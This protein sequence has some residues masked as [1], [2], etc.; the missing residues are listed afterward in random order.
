MERDVEFS[1][2]KIIFVANW[3]MDPVSRKE[4]VS[5]LGETKRVAR[6]AR[7]TTVI[8]CP[9]FVH[10]PACTRLRSDAVILGAQD[11]SLFADG[12]HTGEVSSAMLKEFGVRYVIVG[13]SE[14]RRLGETDA[15]VAQK[16]KLA[17]RNGLRPIMCVG[18][19]E[20][21]VHGE[22]LAT[23]EHQIK[24]SLNG[25]SRKTVKGLIVAYE[26]LWAIGKSFKYAM[27]PSEIHEAVIFIRK[28]LVKLFGRGVGSSIPILYGG[29]VEKEN[30][31]N[32][33]FQGG[34]DGVLVGHASRNTAQIHGMLRAITEYGSS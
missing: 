17:L 6:T 11:L 27:R 21:G 15:I 2:K 34:A 30:I 19:Y 1:M 23:L 28:I 29:S 26:P 13:H 10:I 31:A 3:K 16:T 32:I 5:L 7:T 33:V 18:E 22:H 8:V 20:R 12:A 14:R 4:A 25:I 24:S 9:P